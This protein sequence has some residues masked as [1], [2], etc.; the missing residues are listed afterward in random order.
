MSCA[1]KTLTKKVFRHIIALIRK[2]NA[3]KESSKYGYV[4]ERGWQV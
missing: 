1:N 2:A 3:V 4:S